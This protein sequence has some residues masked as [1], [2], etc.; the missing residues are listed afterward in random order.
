MTPPAKKITVDDLRRKAEQ[1]RDTA[2]DEARRMAK[3]EVTTYA[4]I[5]VVGVV[6][7]V[8]LAY[9]LGTRRA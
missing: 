2:K 1:I 9:L 4:V 7:L 5:G 6:A 8:S 3:E